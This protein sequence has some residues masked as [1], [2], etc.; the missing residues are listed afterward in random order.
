MGQ[1]IGHRKRL[2]PGVITFRVVLCILV[3][4]SA[5][6]VSAHTEIRQLTVTTDGR[7]YD[8]QYAP[9]MLPKSRVLPE[10]DALIAYYKKLDQSYYQPFLDG[11]LTNSYE[12]NLDD[13]RLYRLVIAATSAIL[14]EHWKSE[15][16]LLAWFVLT[17]LGFDTRVAFN[18]YQINLFIFAEEELFEIPSIVENQRRY[19]HFLQRDNPQTASAKSYLLEF[20]PGAG[21]RP[22]S[23]NWLEKGLPAGTTQNKTITFYYK[24]EVFQLE[25]TY[26]SSWVALLSELPIRSEASYFDI[27]MSKA[28][29]GSFWPQWQKILGSRDH[30][31][32]LELLLAFTRGGFDY[33]EDRE[34]FG[35]EKTLIPD[36]IFHYPYSDCEDRAVLFFHLHRQFLPWPVAVVA[37]QNH[38]SIAVA[39]P[40]GCEEPVVF[41]GISYCICDPTGPKG[42]TASE[43]R[44]EQYKNQTPELVK[45]WP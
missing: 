10:Q 16:E 41:N 23:F 35:R 28:L 6:M 42:N 20:V 30:R 18:Q 26:D 33:Q 21:G 11:I 9:D 22:L 12:K 1:R 36:E 7:C 37:F 27:P 40:W 14:P 39:L 15:Q 4:C 8:L 29:S 44:P 32:R 19:Y 45:I 43:Y 31:S 5:I 25:I 3:F 24:E 13:W 38:I 2:L 17:K 34:Q